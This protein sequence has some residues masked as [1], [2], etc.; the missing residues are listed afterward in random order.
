MYLLRVYLNSPRPRHRRRSRT[1]QRERRGISRRRIFPVR[2][3]TQSRQHILTHD[4]IAPIAVIDLHVV[5]LRRTH[6]G[7]R[8]QRPRKIRARQIRL[9]QVGV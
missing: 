4:D 3:F 7:T 1:E 2:H 5:Q 9:S 6:D 8:E